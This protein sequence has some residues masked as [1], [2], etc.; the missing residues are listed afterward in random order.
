MDGPAREPPARLYLDDLRVG[1]RFVSGSLELTADDIIGFARL[2]DPQPFHTDEEAA[3]GSF[4]GGL[5]ASGW[6]TA[7]ITM[8]LVVECLPLAGGV[9][10]A[11]GEIRWPIPTRPGDRLH[12]E[13]EILEVKPSRSRPERGSFLMR[14]V[15]RNQNGEP[16]QEFTPRALAL[17]RA[18]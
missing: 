1:Q 12:V 8:R 11:G 2:Y 4:F 17:R 10:G 7:G 3:R 18:R 5:A 15:T 14:I 9:I 16:V 6:Q 13:I